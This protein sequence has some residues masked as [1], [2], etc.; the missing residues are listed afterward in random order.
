MN[1]SLNRQS[2]RQWLIEH[3]LERQGD[4][5]WVDVHERVQRHCDF[6]CEAHFGV[7]NS[8]GSERHGR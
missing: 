5:H 6:K 1:Y 7:R 4:E 3:A 2:L 8:I